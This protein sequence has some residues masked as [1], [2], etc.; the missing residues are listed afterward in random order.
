MSDLSE[1]V[2][3][4]S[5]ELLTDSRRVAAH[6]GK[7]HKNVLR[8][9]DALECSSEFNRLNFE[10]VEYTDAKGETRREVLMTKDGFMFLAMGFTG[11]EAAA[12]KEAFIKAFNEMAQRLRDHSRNLWAELR[13]LERLES[14][15][16]ARASLGSRLMLERKAAIPG[17]EGRRALLEAKS[18]PRLFDDGE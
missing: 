13:E 16:A 14:A 12:M 9:Y 3:M 8:A 1:F 15:S 4:E 11:K 5:G 17:F 18:Q 10:P 7:P 2:S 6:F